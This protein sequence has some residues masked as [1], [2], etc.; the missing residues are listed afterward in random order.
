MASEL[1][2]LNHFEGKR[3]KVYAQG[4]FAVGKCV[5]DSLSTRMMVVETDK[6]DQAYCYD[7]GIVFVEGEA[8]FPKL[9]D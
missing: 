8:T 5:H 3:V 4:G 9:E 6:G 7:Y 2:I 1:N